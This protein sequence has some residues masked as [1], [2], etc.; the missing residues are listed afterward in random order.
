MFPPF[1][2]SFGD[3]FTAVLINM[4]GSILI[5]VFNTL[6]SAVSTTL[7]VPFLQSLAPGTGMSA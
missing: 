5:G 3:Q 2:S 7:I 6:F 1:V 4:V